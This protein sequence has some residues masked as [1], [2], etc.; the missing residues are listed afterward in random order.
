MPEGVAGTGEIMRFLAE[1]LSPDTYVNI[2]R[3]YYP[4]GNVNSQSYPE[5]NRRLKDSEYEAA[6]QA[7]RDAGLWRFDQRYS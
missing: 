2:M 1:E 4:A 7:A 3:Q 6:V 5:I